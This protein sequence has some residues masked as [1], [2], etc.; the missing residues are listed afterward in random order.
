MLM[1]LAD[2]LLSKGQWH[3]AAEVYQKALS[4]GGLKH[5]GEAR[6]HCGIALI[7]A[8]QNDAAKAMLQTVTGDAAYGL[9]AT[10]WISLAK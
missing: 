9:M 10:L 4:K 1:Q 5:E 6:L 8:K 7:K 2:V 3:E